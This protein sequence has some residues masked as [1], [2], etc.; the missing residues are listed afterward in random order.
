MRQA[1]V[2]VYLSRSCFYC[3]RAKHLLHNKGVSYASIIVDSDPALWDEMEARSGRSTVPQIFIDK[4]PIGGFS[5]MA[6]LDRQGLL[7]PLLFPTTD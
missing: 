2:V 4:H 6:E 7:N 1:E 3:I 5:D